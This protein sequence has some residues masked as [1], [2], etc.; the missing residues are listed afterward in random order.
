MTKYYLQ[1]I[2]KEQFKYV[3]NIDFKTGGIKTMTSLK[4]AFLMDDNEVIKLFATFP[5]IKKEYEVYTV[6]F[7]TEEPVIVN[8]YLS[9]QSTQTEKGNKNEND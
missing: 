9:T 1:S 8:M 4:N 5:D 6:V 2:K 7:Q 3:S